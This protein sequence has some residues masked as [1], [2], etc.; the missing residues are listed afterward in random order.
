MTVTG[1]DLG[2]KAM[3]LVTPAATGTPD[4]GAEGVTAELEDDCW[5]AVRQHAGPRV[6]KARSMRAAPRPW[7]MER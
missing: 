3:E 7:K 2:S 4:D 6:R 1:T 5:A